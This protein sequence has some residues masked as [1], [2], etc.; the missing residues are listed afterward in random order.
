MLARFIQ[1]L[2]AKQAIAEGV[3]LVICIDEVHVLLDSLS[4][5]KGYRKFQAM[6]TIL[7]SLH[8]YNITIF[9]TS[10]TVR[11]GVETVLAHELGFETWRSETCLTFCKVAVMVYCSEVF[12]LP[13]SRP[14]VTLR[15]VKVANRAQAVQA[16]IQI[17]PQMVIVLIFDFFTRDVKMR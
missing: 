14:E 8:S 9:A 12:R 13:P 16:L 17:D 6:W 5:Q 2:F 7:A 11:P 15:K 4:Q 1:A 3:E 10:A